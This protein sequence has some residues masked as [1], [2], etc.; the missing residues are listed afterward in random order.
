MKPSYVLIFI[1]VNETRLHIGT[2]CIAVLFMQ[3]CTLKCIDNLLSV[4]PRFT[5]VHS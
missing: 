4:L 5:Y 3:V 2:T 1:D